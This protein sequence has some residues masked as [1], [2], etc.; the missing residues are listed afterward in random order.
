VVH[1]CF[2]SIQ[3]LRQEDHELEASMDCIVRYYLKQQQQK[4]N[5]FLAIVSHGLIF[6]K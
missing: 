2:P 6:H 1:A 4:K 5:K 3:R